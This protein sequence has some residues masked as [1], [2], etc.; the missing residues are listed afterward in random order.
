M[1]LPEVQIQKRDFSQNCTGITEDVSYGYIRERWG[2]PHVI[3]SLI[4]VKTIVHTTAS[5]G[6]A[7]GPWD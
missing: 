6:G 7:E 3:A 1:A 5:D 4:A 2:S